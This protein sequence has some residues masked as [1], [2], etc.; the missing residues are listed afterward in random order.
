VTAGERAVRGEGEQRG[1]EMCSE[2]AQWKTTLPAGAR[3]GTGQS[4]Q[5][6]DTNERLKWFN[7]A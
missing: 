5:T 6:G 7:N 4:A 3:G 1:S 2:W